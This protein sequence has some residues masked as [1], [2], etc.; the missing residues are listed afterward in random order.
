MK[1]PTGE[2]KI[3]KKNSTN[4]LTDKLLIQELVK[5]I[6]AGTIKIDLSFYEHIIGLSCSDY[7]WRFPDD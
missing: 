2:P 7:Q 4:S 6:K 3:M 5:Q 1:L